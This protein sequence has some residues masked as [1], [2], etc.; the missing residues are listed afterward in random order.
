[1]HIFNM[2][3]QKK[4]DDIVYITSMNKYMIGC[5]ILRAVSSILRTHRGR[6]GSVLGRFPAGAIRA[7]PARLG[8]A[9]YSP[10]CLRSFGLI[11][12]GAGV[13]SGYFLRAPMPRH[14]RRAG[15]AQTRPGRILLPLHSLLR[16][17]RGRRGSVLGRLPAG[18]IRAGPVRLG[19]V[20]YFPLCLRSWPVRLLSWPVWLHSLPVWLA[21]LFWLA[22]GIAH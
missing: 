21:S 13:F 18:A 22:S 19:R 4:L 6:R 5:M 9:G 8:W 14:P 16:T 11:A 20:G 1:M 10:L 15:Q 3:K 7:G 12:E 17:H 2:K